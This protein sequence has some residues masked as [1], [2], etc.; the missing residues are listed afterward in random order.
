[1]LAGLE[2]DIARCRGVEPAERLSR[3]VEDYNGKVN[4]DFRLA[5]VGEIVVAHT[6]CRDIS[7]VD[8]VI[9]GIALARVWS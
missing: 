1:M 2:R 8:D 3:F 7:R 9:D 6:R 5:R 4:E